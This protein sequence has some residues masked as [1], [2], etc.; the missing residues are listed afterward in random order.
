M[1]VASSGTIG[2]NPA[3]ARTM[4]VRGSNGNGIRLF[5]EFE[6]AAVVGKRRIVGGGKHRMAGNIDSRQPSLVV[7]VIENSVRFGS[8]FI[9]LGFFPLFGHTRSTSL[10]DSALPTVQSAEFTRIPRTWLALNPQ[11]ERE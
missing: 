9:G 8:E 6:V 5:D 1:T 2:I 7:E 4:A 10:D 11:V 3:C